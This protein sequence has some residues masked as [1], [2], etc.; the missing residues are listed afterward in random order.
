MV[1]SALIELCGSVIFGLTRSV[2]EHY[3]P[4][5]VE[6]DPG[7]FGFHRLESTGLEWNSHPVDE[8]IFQEYG[9]KEVRGS[10]GQRITDACSPE[11]HDDLQDE[12]ENS[13]MEWKKFRP[14]KIRTLWYSMYFGF[15]IS[16]LAATLIGTFSILVYYVAYQ[17]TLVCL[18]RPKDSIPSKIQWS[19]TISECM[20]IIFLHLWFFVNT[21]FF[22]RS[23]QIMGLKS[24]LFLVSSVFYVL[25]AAYRIALQ[26]LGISRSELTPL[27]RI[28]GNILF[29]FSIGVQS[30]VLA[31]HF[32]RAVVGP[33]KLTFLWMIGSCALT[34]T[35]AIL[36]SYFIYPAYN[37]QD[38]TGKIYIAVF[39]PLITVVLK[40][41]SRLCVQRLW[42]I[43]HPG[44]SFLLLVPLYYGSAVMLRV[45]QV[46]LNTLKSVALIGIIHGIAEVIERSVI[47][48]IDYIYHQ[49]YERQCSSWRSFRTPRRERLATDVAILSMLCEASAIISVNGF[50]HLH[51]YFYTDGKTALELLQ[52]F[53]ITTAVPLV[54]EWFFTCLSIAIET[55]YQNRPIMAVWRRQWKRHITVAIVNALPIAIWTSTSLLIAI[56]GRFPKEKDYCELPFTRP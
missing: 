27:Q 38:K 26:A 21:L 51:E 40:G 49:I 48:L 32:F 23:Y 43:S 46:D 34:F 17:V 35:V 3:D 22:F 25:D 28:P 33:R 47:V 16:I 8:L 19:K 13:A 1:G 55:R 4:N 45:L 50:L 10:A 44:T 15:V 52:S 9:D 54:I 42:R 5:C 36:V 53:A 31:R 12:Q 30:C 41:S 18:A 37:K 20:E 7:T 56:K 14:S 29:S 39:T 24:K 2:A 6:F 11:D